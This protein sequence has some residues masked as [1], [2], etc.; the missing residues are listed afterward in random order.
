VAAATVDTA[1]SR[2]E[3]L[4]IRVLPVPDGLDFPYMQQTIL[5]ERYVTRLNTTRDFDESLGLR[6]AYGIEPIGGTL[7]PWQGTPNRGCGGP[8]G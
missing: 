4:T 8:G 6:E 7:P 3:T 2:I 1:H 5:I